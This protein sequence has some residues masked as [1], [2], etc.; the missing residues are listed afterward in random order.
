MPLSPQLIALA[1]PGEGDKH[2]GQRARQRMVTAEGDADFQ[3]QLLGPLSVF[4][5]TQR[6]SLHSSMCMDSILKD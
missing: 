4:P 1:Q 3:L 5:Q 2:P 6:K